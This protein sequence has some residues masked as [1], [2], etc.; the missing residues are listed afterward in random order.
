MAV[1]GIRVGDQ[2]V[3][4]LLV[5]FPFRPVIGALRDHNVGQ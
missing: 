2:A 4:G 5:E 1:L 3:S